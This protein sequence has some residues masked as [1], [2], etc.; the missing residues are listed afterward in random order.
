MVSGPLETPCRPARAGVLVSAP[1]LGVVF[2]VPVCLLRLTEGLRSGQSGPL[3]HTS[4]G[5]IYKSLLLG[6]LRIHFDVEGQAVEAGGTELGV[7]V[8]AWRG[9]G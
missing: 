6:A 4:R 5:L 9:G 8:A 3:G 2:F 1:S 7:I